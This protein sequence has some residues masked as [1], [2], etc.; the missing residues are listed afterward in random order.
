L[1]L[2][3]N[4]AQRQQLYLERISAPSLPDAAMEPRRVR[5]VIAV[6]LLGL[7][8]WGVL[9]LTVAAVREHVD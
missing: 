5:S 2:A 3:R 7:V 8:L 9:T 1:E 6:F 4:E